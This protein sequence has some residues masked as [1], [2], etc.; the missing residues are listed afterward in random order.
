MNFKALQLMVYS[1]STM[2]SLYWIYRDIKRNARK[3]SK[4]D[5]GS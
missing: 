4:L 2:A 3:H 5:R 1:V